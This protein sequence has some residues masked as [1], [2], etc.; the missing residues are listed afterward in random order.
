MNFNDLSFKEKLGQMFLIG[1]GIDEVNDEIIE[2]IKE[3]KIGG[4]VLYRKNYNSVSNMIDVINKLK[5]INKANN[6]PLFIAIDQ[7]NGRVNRF[8]KELHRIKSPL[9]QAKTRDMNI[10]NEV[11]EITVNILKS[12]GINMNF[13]PCLDI[14]RDE[15]SKSIGN[16]SY[17]KNKEDVIK[18]GIPFM[19]MLQ[20]NNII[21]VIKHFPGHGATNID[22]HYFIPKIKDLDNLLKNDIKVFENA[23]NNNADAIMIGH[24]KLKGFGLKPATI[25][26]KIIK[27]YLLNELNYKGLIVT[28]DLKMNILQYIFGIKN[29][30]FNAINANNDILIIKYKNNDINKIYK[31]IYRKL[32]NNK[33]YIDKIEKSAKKIYDIKLK[34]NISDNA[35]NTKINLNV[36]NNKIDKINDKIE[37]RL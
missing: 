33:K 20:D 10:I 24:L 8:P 16:R 3:Y 31:K 36:I 30:I 1:L 21:S 23:I 35:I 37:K 6:I 29:V 26:K 18:Y 14:I 13:A 12:V 7:E 27:K 28:D 34:Y 2:L 17:G 22:S 9:N 25:N 5:K 19:K 4:I 11:N 15:Y 32:V